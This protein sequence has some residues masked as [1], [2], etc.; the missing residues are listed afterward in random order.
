MAERLTR[1]DVVTVVIPGSYG[2]PRPAVV[3]QSDLLNPTHASLII[4]PCTT[5]LVASPMFRMLM[6]PTPQNKLQAP[7]QIMIDKITALPREKVGRKIGRLSD[8]EMSQLDQMLD[9][10]LGLAG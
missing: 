7:S 5:D 8:H 3:V 6:H 4:C 9:Y 10:V 2:K 1:G